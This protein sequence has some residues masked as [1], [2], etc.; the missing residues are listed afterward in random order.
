M[1]PYKLRA[2]RP[3]DVRFLVDSWSSSMKQQSVSAE[4]RRA[5]FHIAQREIIVALLETSRVWV[6]CDPINDADVI[7]YVVGEPGTPTLLHFVYVKFQHRNLGFAKKLVDRLLRD[8][9]TD[10]VHVTSALDKDQR[11]AVKALGW[12]IAVRVPYYRTICKLSA[13]AAAVA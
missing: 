12:R 5:G 7:G 4:E 13:Q 2:G 11:D 10:A 9:D 6:A 8:A 1:I 3:D